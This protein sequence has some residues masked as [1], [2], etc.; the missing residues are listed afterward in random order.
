MLEDSYKNGYSSPGAIFQDRLEKTLQQFLGDRAS[1]II[2]AGQDILIEVDS[3]DLGSVLTEIKNNPEIS[4]TILKG[5]N[6]AGRKDADS[7]IADISG[8][9]L[10]FSLI[11]KVRLKD[12]RRA[13]NHTAIVSLF[14]QHYRPAR[15]YLSG[16]YRSGN[17]GGPGAPIYNQEIKGFDGFDLSLSLEDDI[18]NSVFIDT[19]PAHVVK[20]D[21]F[22]GLDIGQLIAYMGRFDYRAGIFGELV[23]CQAI[24][25]L[26]QLQI[27][28]RAKYIRML[29]SELFRMINHLEF[30]S[31]ISGLLG[32][33]IARN[34]ALLEKEKILRTT[35]IITGARV[36]PNYMRIGGVRADIPSDLLKKLKRQLPAIYKKIKRIENILARDFVL[37]ERSKDIGTVTNTLAAE[38]GISGPNLRA[39]GSRYDRRKEN[40]YI[41]YGDFHFTIPY[42]RKGDCLERINIRFAEIYQSIKII[43]QVLTRIPV[44]PVIKRINLSHL[45]L[46]LSPFTS[47][48]EC[49]HGELKVF[50]EMEGKSLHTFAVFGPSRSS[51]SLAGVLLEGNSFEDTELILAS[52]DISG[53]ELIQYF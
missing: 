38:F 53:G 21:F 35:E 1:R 27:P 13:K 10:D 3:E 22:E 32:Y 33:D 16:Y 42:G 24:E 41:S 40:D 43:G 23:F 48:V 36:I 30:I 45:D 14:A 18:I 12:G 11:L 39:S 4:L 6:S 46:A 50:G 20:R 31:N 15:S 9:N 37:V 52:L 51:L 7:I 26:L 34:L 19:S 28:K 17:G 47:S 5:L 8:P 25:E 2:K 49:P 29:V 44:G